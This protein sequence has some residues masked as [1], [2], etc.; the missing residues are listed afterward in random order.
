[1]ASDLFRHWKE[2]PGSLLNRIYAAF[3]I[4]S[5]RNGSQTYIIIENAFPHDFSMLQAEYDLKGSKGSNRQ[6]KQWER[7]KK[8]RDFHLDTGGKGLSMIKANA[9]AFKQALTKDTSFLQEY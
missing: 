8:D 2:N 3:T 4:D 9:I 6:R 1:M 5:R 7:T